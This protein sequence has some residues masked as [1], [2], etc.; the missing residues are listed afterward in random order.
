[1]FTQ[2]LVADEGS[3]EGMWRDPLGDLA[4]RLYPYNKVVQVHAQ[5][6]EAR[7][8]EATAGGGIDLPHGG[9]RAGEPCLAAQV[10]E[11]GRGRRRVEVSTCGTFWEQANGARIG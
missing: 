8:G 3:I 1:V 7:G 2:V 6:H 10:A 4:E 11:H 5:V 9:L